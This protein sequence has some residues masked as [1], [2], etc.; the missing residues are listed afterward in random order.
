L[1]ERHPAQDPHVREHVVAGLGLLLSFADELKERT[2][3]AYVHGDRGSARWAVIVI[4][5]RARRILQA[6]RKLAPHEWD[7]VVGILSRAL[8]EAAIDILY[9]QT[10]SSWGQGEKAV[11]LP[12]DAKG[13]L[14]ATHV[15]IFE[16][17]MKGYVPEEHKQFYAAALQTRAAFRLTPTHTW[18]G[19]KT[20]DVLKQL[21]VDVENENDRQ[22]LEAVQKAFRLDSWFVHNNGNVN[23]YTT[24]TAIRETCA[25]YW[26]LQSALISGVEICFRWGLA[27]GLSEADCR[28][29]LSPVKEAAKTFSKTTSVTPESEGH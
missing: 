23:F 29:R 14:F 20:S 6:I 15:F 22:Q 13:G 1:A 4:G 8:V 17:G 25:V 9:L 3:P 19:R 27:L 7:D 18:H 10:T 2:D 5:L 21:L 12:P 16:Q 11:T 28:E 26:P 24:P